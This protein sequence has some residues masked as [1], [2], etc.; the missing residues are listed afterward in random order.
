MSSC[1][2]RNLIFG[3]RCQ[4]EPLHVFEHNAEGRLHV[5]ESADRVTIDRWG[6][7]NDIREFEGVPPIPVGSE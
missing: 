5:F 4:K 7:L 6:S 3:T 1:S 2:S